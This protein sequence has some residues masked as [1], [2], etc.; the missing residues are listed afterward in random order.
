MKL[1]T[2]L[3]VVLLAVTLVVGGSVYGALEYNKQQSVNEVQ[4]A[5]NETAD[6]A[7]D[8]IDADI[9][10]RMD[11]VGFVAS[12]PSMANFNR[13]AASIDPFLDHS[14]FVSAQIVDANGTVDRRSWPC[15]QSG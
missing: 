5:V 2:T 12:Q 3:A 15:C 11:R 9:T 8:Q 4:T 10:E 14:R 6:L 1:R 7:V 13:T